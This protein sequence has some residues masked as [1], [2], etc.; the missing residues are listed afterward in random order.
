MEGYTVP[1][2]QD[3]ELCTELSLEQGRLS[4]NNGKQYL[5]SQPLISLEDGEVLPFVEKELLTPLLDR[6]S[7][8]LWLLATPKSTHVSALHAQ[9]V[10]GRSITITEDP[11]LHLIWIS[12]RVF[13]KPLPA[14]LLSHAFWSHF[15]LHDK[16]LSKDDQQRL[17]EILQAALGF[18]RTYLHLIRHESDLR[19]AHKEHLVPPDL[20]LET[21][22]AFIKDFKYVEDW[23]VSGR[24]HY[25][26]LRLT[27][28]N[29]W[30]KPILRR[31][32]FRKATWQYGEYFA[33]FIAPL[34]FI[35]TTWTVILDSMQVGLQSRPGWDRFGDA[36]AVF[37]VASLIGVLGTVA[38][39]L[40]GLCIL[41][42][43][44]IF[45]AVGK[46][47]R[48]RRWKLQEPRN[49]LSQATKEEKA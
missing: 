24:Y 36:S 17:K 2:Q 37:S 1:F 5:P 27:R 8:W 46:Q 29:L 32:H 3:S 14:Y 11:E 28:L 34:L 18:V 26:E 38:F 16:T 31:W 22:M 10:R 49:N 9:L 4:S 47:I 44:E 20:D 25:G 42:G 19:I 23:Q 33:R 13:I 41:A 48:K 21:W 40:G 35:F 43:R 45:Y 6:M 12:N 15:L 7:P 39:L 30:A